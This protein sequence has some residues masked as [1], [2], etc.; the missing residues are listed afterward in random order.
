MKSDKQF[1]PQSG[2]DIAN[3]KDIIWMFEKAR[4]L[5]FSEIEINRLKHVYDRKK[6]S[7]RKNEK[8]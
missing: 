7:G 2:A 3:G 5:G 8:S 1:D 6:P 4:E